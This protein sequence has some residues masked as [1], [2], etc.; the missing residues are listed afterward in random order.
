MAH[1][2]LEVREI[3]SAVGVSSER[4][5]MFCTNYEHEKAVQEMGAM[6]ALN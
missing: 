6:I 4:Y 2:R 3:T 1:R 5:I